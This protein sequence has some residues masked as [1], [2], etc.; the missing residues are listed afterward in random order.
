MLL[1]D[2][3]HYFCRCSRHL[4]ILL[5]VPCHARSQYYVMT[6]FIYIFG[7]CISPKKSQCWW[8]AIDFLNFVF[9]NIWLDYNERISK[10]FFLQIWLHFLQRVSITIFCAYHLIVYM[11]KHYTFKV[12]ML[13]YQINCFQNN[14]LHGNQ[15]AHQPISYLAFHM[16]EWCPGGVI[17]GLL[18]SILQLN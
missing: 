1:F 11:L 15:R 12:Y 8:N 13:K 16:L 5:L 6:C 10:A 14:G 18:H 3:W 9:C 17:S 7:K 2:T 4:T